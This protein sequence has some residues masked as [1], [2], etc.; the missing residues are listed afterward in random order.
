M[1]WF[2][3]ERTL[4]TNMV[5]LVFVFLQLMIG[6]A[7]SLNLCPDDTDADAVLVDTRGNDARSAKCA[8]GVEAG[9]MYVST[10]QSRRHLTDP[11]QGILSGCGRVNRKVHERALAEVG[12]AAP[13]RGRLHLSL[14]HHCRALEEHRRYLDNLRSP[15]P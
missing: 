12:N 6:T 5:I 2:P 3:L 13:D 7:T 9:N 15:E 10:A 1:R 14:E 11:E 4:N 8:T